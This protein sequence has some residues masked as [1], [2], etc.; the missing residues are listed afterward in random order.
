MD[1]KSLKYIFTQKKINMR[2]KRWLEL[3]VDYDLEIDHHPGKANV[4]AYTLSRKMPVNFGLSIYHP[5]RNIE[6]FEIYGNR[7]TKL[8]TQMRLLSLWN[9]S[10][11]S[12]TESKTLSKEMRN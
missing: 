5:E 3:L 1:L 7:G 8:S 2:Q 10:L 12:S 11:R 6:G 4:V 9:F